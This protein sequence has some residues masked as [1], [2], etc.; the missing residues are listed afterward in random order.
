MEMP[1][2]SVRIIQ[3]SP[4]Y[5]LRLV[6]LTSHQMDSNLKAYLQ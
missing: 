4:S 5:K 1:I 2:L 3:D 6:F